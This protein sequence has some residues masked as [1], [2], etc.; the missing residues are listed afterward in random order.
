[1][2]RLTTLALAMVPAL[3]WTGPVTLNRTIDRVAS[4]DPIHAQ[5]AA[6]ARAV[7]LAYETLVEY[8]YLARPYR[9]RAGLAEGLPQQS[10]DG[11]V[12][13]FRLRPEVFFGPDPCFGTGPDGQPARRNLTAHDVVYSFKRLADTQL[14]SASYWILEGKVAGLDAFREASRG[15]AP[16]DYDLPVEGLRALDDQTFQLTLRAPA[17]QLLWALAMPSAAI[18]PREAVE[19]YGPTRFGQLEVGSGPYRLVAWRR[20]YRMLFERRPGRDTD[21]DATPLL[22]GAEAP[23]CVPFE[24]IRLV[25]MDDPAT[26][27]LAFLSGELD[28]EGEIPRDNWSAVTNP[29]GSLAPTLVRRGIR[30][31]AQPSLDCFYIG[32][33]MDDPVVGRNRKLRQALNA[34]FDFPAWAA[35]NPGRVEPATGPVPPHVAGRLE[36]PFPYSHNPDLARRLLAE[37]GYPD[38]RDP[39]TGR[40]LVLRLE[41]GRTD[42]ETRESTELFAAFLDRLGIALDAHYNNWPAFLQKVGH[43]EAQMFRVGW[44][45]DYP[46]AENF[47]Q[48]FHSRNA[49]PGPNRSNYSNPE[50]DALYGEALR[51]P[52]EATRLERYRAM[53]DILREDCPWI[54]LYHRRDVV[55]TQPRLRNFQMHDFPY[56]M[57]KHWRAA[58]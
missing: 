40:R 39:R 9:L 37:A 25:V 30:M 53:Q 54:F 2:N 10:T 29:D 33:N 23:A 6:A 3:A 49:S 27:W 12:W 48:L 36:S 4:L 35:L 16:T 46:D 38:G 5:A 57:E 21:R 50:F 34:A 45:A 15:S 18:V 58:D 24:R 32:F 52:D 13:T 11:L 56:G 19:H 31:H 43:R 28:L 14:A 7:A 22:P 51:V 41:L 42:Q 17:P 20:D 55:L 47:L 26:R 44:L 1:M 8:D